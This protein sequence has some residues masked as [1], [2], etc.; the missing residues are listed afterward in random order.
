MEIGRG[1]LLNRKKE[2]KK[3]KEKFNFKDERNNMD[4]IPQLRSK[5]LHARY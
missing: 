1:S 5:L 4:F 3:K 2:R